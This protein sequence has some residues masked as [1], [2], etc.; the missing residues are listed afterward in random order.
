MREAWKFANEMSY[1]CIVYGK[2]A[3][4]L[5]TLEAV[6]GEDTLRQALRIY[7]LRYRFTHPTATDFLHTLVEVSGRT[8]LEPY[9]AQAIY[10]TEVLDYSVDSLTSGPV[11]WWEGK[12]AE[13]PFHTSVT[14]RR[15]GTFLFP[16][17][18][19][20]GF[21]DGS[22]EQVSL[23]RQR[24]LDPLLLGQTLAGVLCPG[25]PGSEY[26]AGRQFVQ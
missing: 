21:E 3:T 5:A 16:V 10:G 24:P 20:V 13:G 2:T 26:P 4:V 9:L 18:L 8:D 19:E 22:K 6:L 15:K 7:F 23:G 17:K 11:D 14:V 1:G 12:S 25:R